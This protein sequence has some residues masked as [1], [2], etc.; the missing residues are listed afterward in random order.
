[1][2]GAPSIGVLCTL[3]LNDLGDDAEAL[4]DLAG[5]AHGCW[6]RN[7][8]RPGA[9]ALAWHKA[10]TPQQCVDLL[11]DA[12]RLVYDASRTFWLEADAEPRC[13]LEQ[14]A[15]DVLRFHAARVP[16]DGPPV[17]GCEWWVQVRD[18]ASTSASIGLHWD[19]DEELKSTTGEVRGRGVA[20]PASSAELSAFALGSTSRRSSR[21]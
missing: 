3:P 9:A 5:V 13:A 8:A 19:T 7:S 12:Q 17:M 4:P 21:R 18:S 10:L 15:L 2:A 1:M 14:L 6:C 20:N 16:C 11:N